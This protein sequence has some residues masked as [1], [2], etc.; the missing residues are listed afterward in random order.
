MSEKIGFSAAKPILNVNSV[1]ASLDY[2][3][4]KLGFDKV[5]VWN[6]Q[7]NF[8]EAEGVLTFA[9]IQRGNFGLMLAQQEQGGNGM[10]IYLD[11]DKR[12]DFDQLYQEFVSAGAIIKS[13]PEYKPWNMREMLVQDLDGHVLRIGVPLTHGH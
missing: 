3:C 12:E 1:K 8:N 11:V 5:F 9:E 7:G 13:A 10:W 2:Y 6:D 4:S